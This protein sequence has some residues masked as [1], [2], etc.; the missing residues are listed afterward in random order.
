MAPVA[1]SQELAKP[2]FYQR[3]SVK[4]RS[5][6]SAYSLDSFIGAGLRYPDDALESRTEGRVITRFM[7]DETG[8]ISRIEI[9]RSSG[10]P[11]LDAEARR[12]IAAMP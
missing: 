4:P 11:S 5:P 6:G 2:A 12:I 3:L 9:V 7:V 1:H 8:A 10:V